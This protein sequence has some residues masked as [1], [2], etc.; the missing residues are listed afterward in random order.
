MRRR[1]LKSKVMMVNKFFN[2]CSGL[3]THRTNSLKMLVF[4][5]TFKKKINFPFCAVN[6]RLLQ[7]GFSHEDNALFLN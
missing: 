1:F 6:T 3:P 5:K 7:E 2:A 4:A